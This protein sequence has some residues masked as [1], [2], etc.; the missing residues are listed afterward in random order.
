MIII[1]PVLFFRRIFRPC[2]LIF[3]FFFKAFFFRAIFF[4]FTQ[5][6]LRHFIIAIQG[7]VT[8]NILREV[9]NKVVLT[10][11]HECSVC[12]TSSKHKF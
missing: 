7:G 11:A 8:S 1:R 3:I 9:W 12:L 2:L 6:N 4:F 10:R 5:T